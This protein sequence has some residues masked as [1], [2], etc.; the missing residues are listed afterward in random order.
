VYPNLVLD[1]LDKPAA[2]SASDPQ[3]EAPPGDLESMAP[4]AE[5]DE[6]EKDKEGA[7]A[8]AEGKAGKEE[9]ADD[10][11]KALEQSLKQGKK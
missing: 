4:E 5:E 8:K 9:E 1:S 2:A 7:D 10:P 6:D 3:L 11:A